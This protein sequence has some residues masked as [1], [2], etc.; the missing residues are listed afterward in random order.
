MSHRYPLSVLFAAAL[1]FVT[2]CD[3]GHLE[4]SDDVAGMY[5]DDDAKIAGD[6]QNALS[7]LPNATVEAFAD[8]VPTFVR[9]D[10]GPATASAS[11]S[12]SVEVP[13][14]TIAPVFRLSAANLKLIR[15]E[16]EASGRTH[17][18]YQQLKN[19]TS[20]VGGDLVLHVANGRVYAAN[21]TA[22]DGVSLAATA[23]ISA[24]A[25]ISAAKADRALTGVSVGAPRLTYVV[26][27]RDQKL[28][29]AYEI[30]VAG[31]R[32]QDPVMDLVYVNAKTGAV[33]DV[34]PTIHSALNRA[35]YSANNGTS[36]PGTLKRSEGGAASTDSVVNGELR[37]SRPDLQLLQDPLQPR[38]VQQR[39]RAAEEHGPLRRQLRQRVLERDA[40][41][42]RRRRRRA[43]LEPRALVRRDH[44]RAHPRGHRERVEPHLLERV[45][46]AQRGHERHLRRGLRGVDRRRR[47]LEH[48]EGRRDDLDPGHRGRR[49]PLHEQP[50]PGR[51]VEGLLPRALH[52]HLGQRRRPLE[53]G[54]REPRVLPALAGRHPPAQQDHRRRPRAWAS[55]RRAR[56]S[57]ARTRST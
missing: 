45:G 47:E 19:G 39:R 54:H 37:L 7:A 46:R 15:T 29:Y 8:G 11:L 27:S 5:A 14:S 52:R 51:V 41:G 24:E 13:L 18:R 17:L 9:G 10:L 40:D 31:T 6:V 43:G 38:L 2:A 20:V 1:T 33:V 12:A 44:P 55:P 16:T 57:T 4:G 56:S 3:S 22:R 34:H 25:A 42:L 23:T 49:A 30:A 48:L 28:S 32:G 53:L 26:S 50:D 35:V 36:L 21:G